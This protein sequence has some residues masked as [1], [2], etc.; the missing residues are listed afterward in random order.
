ME[1]LAGVGRLLLRHGHRLSRRRRCLDHAE[2]T[3]PVLARPPLLE[4]A[5]V[6]LVSARPCPRIRH[7]RV[8]S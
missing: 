3:P 8:A 5:D 7:H 2:L 6:P 4:V 1:R